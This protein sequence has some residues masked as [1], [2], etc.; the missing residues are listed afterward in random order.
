MHSKPSLF[1]A[2]MVFPALVLNRPAVRA[3]E[4]FRA[5]ADRPVDIRHIGLDLT[6]DIPGK[7]AVAKAKID[8]LALRKVHS[9]KFDAVDFDVSTVT[10]ARGEAPAAPVE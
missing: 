10:F 5:A 4:P 8:L 7:T 6:V 3:D 1:V 2:V 9:I